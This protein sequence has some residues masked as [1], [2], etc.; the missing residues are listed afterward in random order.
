MR[1]TELPGWLVGHALNEWFEIPGTGGVGGVTIDGYNGIALDE[2]NSEIVVA[3]GGEA[4]YSGDNR[5]VSLILDADAPVWVTRKAPSANPSINVAH[6]ADG[7]P[8]ARELYQSS[9]VIESLH[10]VFLFGAEFVY[11]EA[12]TFPDVDAFDLNTNQWDP[13]GTWAPVPNGGGYGAVLNPWNRGRAHQRARP[14]ERRDADL[15]PAGDQPLG[16]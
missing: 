12:Y 11:G 9:H 1:H 5:V 8:A 15:V 13:A 14:L 2:T 7:M 4:K 3:A 16:R 6:Y 10:R